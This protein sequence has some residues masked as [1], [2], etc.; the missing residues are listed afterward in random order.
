MKLKLL[1]IVLLALACFLAGQ[2]WTLW[3]QPD[4]ITHVALEQMERSD[5]AAQLMR[6]A[7][8]AQQ[9]PVLPA[10]FVFLVGTLVILWPDL[11]R[12]GTSRFS[13]THQSMHKE[14]EQ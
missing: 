12:P 8:Q 11:R 1:L 2:L 9:W 3:V 5:Q 6:T 14:T 4:L 10:V 13:E 7:S